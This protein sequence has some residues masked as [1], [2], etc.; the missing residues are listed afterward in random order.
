MKNLTIS[1]IILIA[2]FFLSA[3]SCKKFVDIPA[4]PTQILNYKVFED[5]GTASK[6]LTGIYIQMIANGNLFSSGNTTFYAGLSA[7]ELYY[8][9]ND[10][11]QEFLKNEIGSG[12]QN[13]IS[14]VF[15]S[16]AYKYIYTANACI[17]GLV[18][19]TTLTPSVKS[20][21][22]GEAKFIRAYCYF[23]LVNLFG[24]VPLITTTNYELNAT[25]PRTSKAIVYDQIV[26]DLTD[27]Q[28]LLEVSYVSKERV[29]PNKWA[30]TA[31]LARTYLYKQDWANAI[32]QS[33]MIISSGMYALEPDLNNVF[34][35]GSN[36]TIFQL[37]P[38]TN[39]INTWEGSVILPPSNT[40]TP[41]YLLTNTLL[42][43][44][45][46]GDLRRADWVQSRIFAGQT[47]FYPFKYKIQ[48]GTPV[49][50]YYIYLRLAEQYLIRAEANA[51]Q[52][53]STGSQADLNAVRNRAGLSNTSA[54]DKA[55]L[56]LAIEH[57]RQI[58]FLAEW[59]H[60]WFD[61][62]RTNRA[63]IVLGALK[64]TTWQ[65]TDTLWPIP[66]GQINLNSALTQN[67]G[68]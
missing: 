18:A 63:N 24:D 35:K 25:M 48:S 28:N 12:G 26:K 14:V 61:L 40:V 50:E 5:D 41:T 16:P 9:S 68:Y 66:S 53:D 15:W 67:A 34:L 27:A 39:N 6:A 33:S 17:E 29:R 49:K 51:Q 7:D 42:N 54:N 2:V 46:S 37:Q 21:L 4:T 62:I 58:E 31:L 44:F 60:R 56:L 38:G 32:A 13:L 45:E 43:S 3:A 57:E 22:T 11:K 19:S 20:R 10:S 8:Y 52:N 1:R 64:P 55:S 47:I 23:Y 65:Q 59:G 36:E 30:A